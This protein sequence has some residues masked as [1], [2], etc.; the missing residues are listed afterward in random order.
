MN[1]K[2]SVNEKTK[3]SRKIF[4]AIKKIEKD[5]GQG[6]FSSDPTQVNECNHDYEKFSHDIFEIV[7]FFDREL[8]FSRS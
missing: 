1:V 2:M 6:R 4:R 8:R 7:T 3:T 5:I